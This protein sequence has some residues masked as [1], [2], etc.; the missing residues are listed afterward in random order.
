M[1]ELESIEA[2]ITRRGDDP[3]HFPTTAA[4]LRQLYTE[5]TEHSLQ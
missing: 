2:E 3:S 4:K 5:R 1:L